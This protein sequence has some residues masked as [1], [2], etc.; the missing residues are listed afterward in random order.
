MNHRTWVGG[1]AILIFIGGGGH[2]AEES[3]R[4]TYSNATEA[5]R[6]LGRWVCPPGS[7]LCYRPVHWV[8]GIDISGSGAWGWLD[9]AKDLLRDWIQYVVVP[10]DRVQLILFDDEVRTFSPWKV[11]DRDALLNSLLDPVRVR[12]GRKGSAIARPARRRWSWL[13][14]RDERKKAMSHVPWWSPT[15]TAPIRFP[16]PALRWPD[17]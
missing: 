5:C 10:K 16:E 12:E 8:L 1:L 4:F 14:K 11:E 9:V 6:Y 15:G 13:R 7:A 17:P 2:P 3:D